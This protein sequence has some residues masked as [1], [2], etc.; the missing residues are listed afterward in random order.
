MKD[1]LPV[2]KI[3]D[4]AIALKGGISLWAVRE[5]SFSFEAGA[6]DP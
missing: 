4:M 1:N 5:E 2:A 6:N 3:A